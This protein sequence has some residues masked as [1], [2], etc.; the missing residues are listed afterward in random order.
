MQISSATRTR[1]AWLLASTPVVLLL[2]HYAAVLPHEFMHSIVAWL[3]GIKANP[4]LIGWGGTSILNILLLIHVDENVDY[5]AALEAGRQW[6]VALTAF[7]GPGLANGGLYLL[8]R[9]LIE[10][11]SVAS[12]PLLAYVLF[13]FLFMNLANLYDYV[14]LRVFATGDVYHFELGTGISPWVIYAVGGYLV[15]WG[16]VDFYRVVLPYTLR[17]CGFESRTART[18]VLIVATALMFGYFAIPSLLEPDNFSQLLSRTSLLAIPL[19]VAMMWRQIVTA[20]LS[21][22]GS[23]APVDQAALAD[24]AVSQRNNRD[25]SP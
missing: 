25:V 15:L 17:V 5:T 8:S 24:E 16:L 18:V 7:A 14:P 12:R 6:Q 4:L 22:R 9:R 11:L 23:P 20:D 19:I 1:T 13:W 10:S 2:T 3:L 21:A